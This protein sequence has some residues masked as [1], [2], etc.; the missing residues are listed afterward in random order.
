LRH[1]RSR[2]LKR[3]DGRSRLTDQGFNDDGHHSGTRHVEHVGSTWR[4][5]DDASASVWAAVVDFDDDR[6]LSRFVTF[7]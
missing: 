5:V 6:R 3:G 7:A 2:G 4:E 1:C